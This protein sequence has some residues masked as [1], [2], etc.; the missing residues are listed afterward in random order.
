MKRILSILA[1]LFAG[2]SLAK[3][4]MSIAWPDLESVSYIRDRAATKEDVE[5]GR[6]VF[7]LSDE[8]VSI[9]APLDIPVPQ[10]S[11]HVDQESGTRTPCVIIQAE[12]ARGQKFIGCRLLDGSIMAGTFPEFVLLGATPPKDE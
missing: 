1:A 5:A 8:G 11:F 4:T 3:E 7:V 12:E 6:A 2:I 10:Y 9:G